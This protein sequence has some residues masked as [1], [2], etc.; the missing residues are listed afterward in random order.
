MQIVCGY[1]LHLNNKQK[2]KLD[3]KIR[4]KKWTGVSERQRWLNMNLDA[5]YGAIYIY[6][7]IAFKYN[8]SGNDNIAKTP[9]NPCAS[10]QFK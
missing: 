3:G 9:F 7:Y 4:K 8:N 1:N 2:E 5:K 6:I 10:L